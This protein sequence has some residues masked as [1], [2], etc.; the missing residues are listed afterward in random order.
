VAAGCHAARAAIKE[1]GVDISEVFHFEGPLHVTGTQGRVPGRHPQNQSYSSWAEFSDPDGNTWLLQEIKTRLPGR[2]LSN[3]DVATLTELLQETEQ[4]HGA[5]EPTAPKHHWSG[6]Y[7]A[8]IV[9]RQRGR[10]PEEA[11]QDAVLHVEAR[12]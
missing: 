11:A 3:F 1:H 4:R 10:T 12:R 9:A 5:Y 8:Y 2:G 7:A 6:W